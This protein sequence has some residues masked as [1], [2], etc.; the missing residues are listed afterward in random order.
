M[1][2]IH[3][4]TMGGAVCVRIVSAAATAASIYCVDAWMAVGTC[5]RRRDGQ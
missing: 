2:S 4:Q 1:N 5:S 3:G